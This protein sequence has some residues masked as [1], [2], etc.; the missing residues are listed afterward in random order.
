M[1]STSDLR[2]AAPGQ[3]AY[4]GAFAPTPIG[5]AFPTARRVVEPGLS[6]LAG[7]LDEGPLA[8]PRIEALLAA[9]PADAEILLVDGGSRDWTLPLALR[10]AAQD[11]RV[12]VIRRAGGGAREALACSALPLARAAYALVVGSGVVPVP[13]AAATLEAAL[14]AVPEAAVAVATV[15]GVPPWCGPGHVGAQGATAALLH[16]P[17]VALEAGLALVRR[18]ATAGLGA[19]GSDATLAGLLLDLT[20]FADLVVLHVPLAVPAGRPRALPAPA[21]AVCPVDLAQFHPLAPPLALTLRE[22]AVLCEFPW[23]GRPPL[24]LA[25]LLAAY[26]DAAGPG[27]AVSLL[28][29]PAFAAGGGP[30]D[31]EA[32]LVGE[33]TGT[34]GRSLDALPDIVVEVAPV[35][36]AGRPGLITA[37]H[38]V[39]LLPGAPSAA[40]L[41]AHACGRCVVDAAGLR[42]ALR[43]L[44]ADP[45]AARA[46]RRLALRGYAAG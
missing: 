19:A 39:A 4:A 5:A 27:D 17:A 28:L 37:A 36:A 44:A 18:S 43:P 26:V 34:L 8:G 20:S 2:L 42:A 14:D 3:L 6:L 12:T 32:W 30:A 10:A 25:E 13:G 15:P 24:G 33:L 9:A 7:L 41:E 40:R 29:A 45:A 38:A 31:L 21:A 35:P 23:D 16:T 11:D 1:P 46:A 22:R